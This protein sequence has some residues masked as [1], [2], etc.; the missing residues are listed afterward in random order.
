MTKTITPIL[1]TSVLAFLVVCCIFTLLIPKCVSNSY[2]VL[3]EKLSLKENML[4]SSTRSLAA[5]FG[6]F[7]DN[8]DTLE[9]ITKLSVSEIQYKGDKIIGLVHNDSTSYVDVID[10]TIIVSDSNGKLKDVVSAEMLGFDIVAPG[11]EKYFYTDSIDVNIDIKGGDTFNVKL[12]EGE[13]S[14]F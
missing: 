8:S 4:S 14:P 1:F 7:S 3:N 2:D 5:G 6:E 9:N 13:R 12:V 11:K 10:M